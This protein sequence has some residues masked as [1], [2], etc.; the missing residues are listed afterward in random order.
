MVK[1]LFPIAFICTFLIL[2]L[3]LAV[4]PAAAV[5][6]TLSLNSGTG[7]SVWFVSGEPSLV[8]NG[9]DLTRFGVTLPATVRSLSLSVNTPVPG[10]PI[11]AVVYQD[12][13][14]GTPADA[15][16]AGRQQVDIT[17]AGVFT[18]TFN[19]P[20][21]INQP[22]IWVGFYL[23]VNFRF[24]ADTSGTSIL[25]YWAWRPGGTFDLNQ[26]SGAGVLGPADGTAPVL[27][28]MGGIARISAVVSTNSVTTTV[29]PGATLAPN[30]TP[31]PGTVFTDSTGFMVV[32]PNCGGVL[33][34][35]GDLAVT[36]REEF[37]LE[38]QPLRVI[39]R[40]QPVPAGYVQG[41][42][43]YVLT[44]YVNGRAQSTTATFRAPVTHCIVPSN[45][46]DVSRGL[47][48]QAWDLPRNWQFLPTVAYNNWLCAEL[49]HPGIITYFLP[50]S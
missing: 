50:A 34:D 42:F 32:Y 41:G 2:A 6:V 4:L 11:D 46:A 19:T 35:R 12:A 22:V 17:Q 47:I 5:D 37:G 31:G 44:A 38:C 13:N 9:F 24:N 30:T 1:K 23:P 20:I 15:T 16:L 21:T 7:N 33:R 36:L 8:M 40:L 49:Y 14:G 39:D 48:A 27:I 25:S 26:L 10:T 29:T 18:V 3:A 43:Y 45:P 28:N